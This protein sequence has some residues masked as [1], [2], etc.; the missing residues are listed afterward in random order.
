MSFL[1]AVS[2]DVRNRSFWVNQ[3]LTL[4]NYKDTNDD[5]SRLM[6]DNQV[7]LNVKIH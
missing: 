1:S 3:V 6:S 4:E 5:F 2:E 7:F